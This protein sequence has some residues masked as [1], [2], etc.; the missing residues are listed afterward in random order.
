[1]KIIYDRDGSSFIRVSPVCRQVDLL[2]NRFTR[3]LATMTTI[4]M[5][6][7]ISKH[8]PVLIGLLIPMTDNI[9]TNIQML[10]VNMP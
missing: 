2:L 3:S 7:L 6:L 4:D 1:M 5:Q 9:L 10:I 8:T